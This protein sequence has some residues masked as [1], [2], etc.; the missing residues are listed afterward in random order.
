M[1]NCLLTFCFATAD[2]FQCISMMLAMWFYT[3]MLANKIVTSRG[4]MNVAKC[5]NMYVATLLSILQ[6]IRQKSTRTFL[7]QKEKA[8]EPQ[9]QTFKEQE[10]DK[11]NKMSDLEQQN[12]AL[13]TII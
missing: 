3:G 6:A 5:N 7:H 2:G 12:D 10:K 9:Q 8:E 1:E 4:G 11:R 13:E